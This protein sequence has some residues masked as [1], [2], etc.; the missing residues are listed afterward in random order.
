[1]SRVT[2]TDLYDRLPAYVRDADTR[3]GGVTRALLDLVAAE[4]D[5]IGAQIDELRDTWFVET[6]PDW[7]V[8]YVAD[9]LGVPL[10]HDVTVGEEL[11]AIVSPRARVANTI[12]YRRRKGTASVLESYAFDVSGWRTVAVEEFERLLT[13]QHLAHPRTHLPNTVDLR[14]GDNLEATPGPFAPHAHTVDVHTVA[15][16]RVQPSARPNPPNVTLHSHRIDGLL[17]PLATAQPGG[18]AAG[19]YR[20]DLLGRDRA[21]VNPP[22]H[23]PGVEVRTGEDEVPAPLR[24]RR[25]RE[26]LD[27]RRAALAAG[28]ADPAPRWTTR[29]PFQV[30]V[31]PAAGDAP[32]PV[33]AEQVEVCHLDPWK[34]AS[35]SGRIRVDPLLGR[36]VVP[37]PVPARLLVTASPGGIPGVGAS[38]APRPATVEE[39]AAAGVDWQIGVSRDVSPVAGEIVGTLADAVT[40]W[41]AQ[42]AG[43]TGV[44]ALM[45]NERHD[46]DLTDAHRIL[47]PEGSRLTIVAA[48]WPELPVVGGAPGQVGRRLGI[49]T[50]ERLQPAVVGDIE[51]RG[52]APAGS[53]DPGGVTLD[54][55][56]LDGS[57]TVTGTADQQ[58][59]RLRLRHTTQVSGGIG[60]TGDRT[61]LQVDVQACQVGPVALPRSVSDLT[62]ADTV[63]DGD[64]TAAID[65][66]GAAA[67]LTGVTTLGTAAVKQLEAS[68]CLLTGP[69]AAVR[70]QQGCVRYSYVAPGSTTPR[71]HRC[72]ESPVPA[73]ASTVR[74][75]RRYAVLADVAGAALRTAGE[76]GDE[77]GAF[78]V[79]GATHREQNIQIALFEYLRVG[80]D[81]GVV[82]VL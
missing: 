28:G 54:G 15:L 40:A 18:G 49:V 4:A 42:P 14:A 30:F 22:V 82:R 47:V 38:P 26:Q 29:P 74:G 27:A 19:R 37:A 1:M 71:R 16:H 11:A 5:L 65:A 75:D 25:L 36:V 67:E 58:L 13:T 23:D 78:G 70:R 43:T 73:F 33:P 6:C 9:L 72:I 64:G 35:P 10:T 56:L 2:G 24:R 3:A 41:N 80:I 20:I 66:P 7:A 53:D 77:V 76:R 51:V 59:G 45:E 44:I 21:L 55:L 34:P 63:V 8:P 17:V 48:G 50:A 68:S 61:L 62:I 79:V 39:L 60:A 57:L 69:V 12:R 81:A 52:R 32:A 46:V 31:V